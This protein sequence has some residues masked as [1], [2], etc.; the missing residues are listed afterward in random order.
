MPKPKIF[1]LNYAML[2][3]LIF[4]TLLLPSWTLSCAL[5]WTGPKPDTTTKPYCMPL[6][7]ARL[8]IKAAWE[9]DFFADLV[10]VQVS[11]LAYAD[12]LQVYSDSL[13][14]I[15]TAERGLYKETAEANAV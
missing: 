9:R 2:K 1:K 10:S 6:E 5:S 13:L 11:D 8:V 3:K 14:T 7:D 15:R 4:L 12:K